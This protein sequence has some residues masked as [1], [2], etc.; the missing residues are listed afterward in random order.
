MIE[1]KILHCSVRHYTNLGHTVG[2]SIQLCGPALPRVTKTIKSH[3]RKEEQM[4]GIS[5]EGQDRCCMCDC[6]PAHVYKRETDVRGHGL[7]T[8]TAAV[9]Y[10]ASYYYY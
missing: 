9:S 3:T 1:I 8:V 2:E 7:R 5:N 6:I 4:R 10:T